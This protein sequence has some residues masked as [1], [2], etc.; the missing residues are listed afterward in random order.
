MNG[1]DTLGELFA[2][3]GSREYPSGSRAESINHEI[4][5]AVFQQ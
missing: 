2:G 4:M 3:F 5:F 1:I